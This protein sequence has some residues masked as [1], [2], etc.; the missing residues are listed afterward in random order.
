ML[1]LHP[2][3]L[4]SQAHIYVPHLDGSNTLKSGVFFDSLIAHYI[5][6]IYLSHTIL[7]HMLHD[8]IL[9]M[10]SNG[11]CVAFKFLS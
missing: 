1:I 10:D 5:V 4:F 2:G 11:D 3:A 6:D 8:H 9:H 7:L